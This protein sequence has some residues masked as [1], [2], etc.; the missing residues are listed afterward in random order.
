MAMADLAGLVNQFAIKTNI[1]RRWFTVVFRNSEISGSA[2]PPSAVCRPRNP[3]H[4]NIPPGNS[5]FRIGL[6]PAGPSSVQHT[7]NTAEVLAQRTIWVMAALGAGLLVLAL[8]L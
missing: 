7:P 8:V 1:C 4:R 5:L 2:L 3:R 6:S